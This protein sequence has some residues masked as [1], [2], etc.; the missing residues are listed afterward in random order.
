MLSISLIQP[1]PQWNLF[2]SLQCESLL[3]SLCFLCLLFLRFKEPLIFFYDSLNGTASP[4]SVNLTSSLVEAG[5]VHVSVCVFSSLCQ[6]YSV[7]ERRWSSKGLQPLE[8]STLHKA[9]CLTHHLTMFGAS[10][11]VHPGAVVLLPPVYHY[12]I[13]ANKYMLL[14]DRTVICRFFIFECF[15]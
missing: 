2:F 13:L 1:A 14:N 11:F 10:L 7:M 9:H 6:Y 12:T 4:L 5:P 8:G 15:L 3:F